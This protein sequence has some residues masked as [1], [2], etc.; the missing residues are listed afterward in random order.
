MSSSF[1]SL[2]SLR[3]VA[4][5]AAVGTVYS[6][7]YRNTIQCEANEKKIAHTA[8]LETLKPNLDEYHVIDWKH[9][10]NAKFL[11]D[12]ALH[13]TLYGD[14][15]VETI[16]I[17]KHNTK[18][19]IYCILKFGSTLNGYPGILHGGISAL[20]LDNS[21]GVLFMSMGLPP[22]FTAN[23]NINYR[24]ASYSIPLHTL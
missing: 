15:K 7:Y 13:E 19:E 12:H 17:Y 3:V 18:P 1:R 5:A 9:E 6:S 10:K 24:F 16:E 23:L 20:V 14:E 2:K 11:K 22:A 8:L 21:Y 4:G